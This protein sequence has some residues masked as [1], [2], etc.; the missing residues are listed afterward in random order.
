MNVRKG[1]IAALTDPADKGGIGPLPNVTQ[2]V[3]AIIKKEADARSPGGNVLSSPRF[4]EEG[5]STI[6]VPALIGY[7]G[8][9]D[10]GVRGWGGGR[11]GQDRG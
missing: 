8:D 7:L 2:A 3:L 10:N 1:T 4:L 9:K 6:S 11:I 5:A